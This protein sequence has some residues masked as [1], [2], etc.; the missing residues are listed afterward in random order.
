MKIPV[1]AIEFASYLIMQVYYK[2]SINQLLVFVMLTTSPHAS[3]GM[4][5]W[6]VSKIN[7][8]VFLPT[9]SYNKESPAC[10]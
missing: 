4:L 8:S 1:F 7:E 6:E 5:V 10:M 3:L 9:A 2:H